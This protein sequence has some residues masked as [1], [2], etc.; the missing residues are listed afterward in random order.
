[1]RE[2][3]GLPTLK[4]ILWLFTVKVRGSCN[5]C[6]RSPVIGDHRFYFLLIADVWAFTI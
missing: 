1:M 6:Q 3:E 5:A 4:Y 2:T